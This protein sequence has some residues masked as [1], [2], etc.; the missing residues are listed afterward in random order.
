LT[1]T[2]MANGLDVVVD[3]PRGEMI[4]RY[5]IDKAHDVINE[6]FRLEVAKQRATGINGKPKIWTPGG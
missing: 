5:M 2:L 3:H 1:I 6:Y 4:C